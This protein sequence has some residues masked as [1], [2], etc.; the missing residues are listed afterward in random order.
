M[1][2]RMFQ[3]SDARRAEIVAFADYCGCELKLVDRGS[4][5]NW[6]RFSGSS[7]SLEK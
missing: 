7:D 6:G 5:L 3:Y 4:G 2:S 1:K